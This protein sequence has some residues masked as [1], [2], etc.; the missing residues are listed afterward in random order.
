M[1]EGTLAVYAFFVIFPLALLVII[2]LIARYLIRK[3]NTCESD[4]TLDGKTIIVTGGSSGLGRSICAELA[5]RGARV[6]VACRTKARRDSTG[7]FLRNKT[8][9]FNVRVMYV[10]FASLDS[11]WEFAR[12]VS[13]SEER[14][15]MIINNAGVLCEHE[16]TVDG[17]DRMMCV[18]YIGHFLLVNLLSDR[19]RECPDSPSRV[20]NVVCG[21]AVH[22]K[23]DHLTKDLEG[24]TRKYDLKQEYRNSKLASLLFT[25]EMAKRVPKDY[26]TSI[27]VDP[28]LLDSGLYQHV[29]GVGGKV[30]RWLAKALYRNPDHEG[31]QS[32]I[33]CALISDIVPYAGKIFKDCQVQDVDHSDWN[34]QACN[35]L[36]DATSELIKSKGISFSLKGQDEDEE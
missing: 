17:L 16:V 13:E 29:P 8:G 33:H 14:L 9:S 2:L 21:S 35:A 20:I 18:N 36:W 7:F 1:I 24:K 10:D 11:I 3:T 5:K 31:L 30:S 6:I 25:K 34:E 26:V 12:E 15:D 27:A 19:L 32:L 28:G 23:T 22:A 4:E